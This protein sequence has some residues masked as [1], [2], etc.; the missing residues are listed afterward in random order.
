[1]HPLDFFIRLGA[2]M[3]NLPNLDLKLLPIT[4]G[5]DGA[6]YGGFIGPNMYYVKGIVRNIPQSERAIVLATVPELS[7]R[8]ALAELAHMPG[9]REAPS[10]QYAAT[11]T[12]L[13]T[14]NGLATIETPDRNATGW[15]MIDN[16]VIL[17]ST[18]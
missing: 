2:T 4:P 1:M 14:N 16:I 3:L 5:L 7:H 8:T 18:S 6:L 10:G 9:L 12:V 13:M 15:I 11:Y 17:E